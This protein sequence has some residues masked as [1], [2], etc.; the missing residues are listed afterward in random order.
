MSGLSLFSEV[1]FIVRCL[2]QFPPQEGH[3]LSAERRR[4]GTIGS[5]T[6]TLDDTFY[7]HRPAHCIDE[8][9]CSSRAT[10]TNLPSSV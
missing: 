1:S 6:D 7:H 10:T 9:E 8:P 3:G 2:C 4:I 5:N